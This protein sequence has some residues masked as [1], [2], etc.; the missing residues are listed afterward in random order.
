MK[1][2]LVEKEEFTFPIHDPSYSP[3]DSPPLWQ[4]S[5]TASPTPSYGKKCGGYGGVPTWSPRNSGSYNLE[6]SCLFKRAKM[7]ENDDEKLEDKMDGLWEDL[8]EEMMSKKHAKKLH[9]FSK[10]TSSKNNSEMV[11]FGCVPTNFKF[12][13]K[14]NNS[15]HSINDHNYNKYSV[16][17][18]KNVNNKGG[19]G[20]LVKSNKKPS[21]V[22][23]MKVLRKFFVLQ[24]S[25]TK[26]T[27]R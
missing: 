9:E 8:N 26:R 25:S 18:N 10:R 5:P 27:S 24:Q 19:V 17:Y 6:G 14:N 1:Q 23:L 20:N 22:V 15:N 3:I 4:L 11:E 13:S 21:M 7:E 16:N 2:I 12:V